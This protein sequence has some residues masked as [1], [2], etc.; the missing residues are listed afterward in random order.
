[1]CSH[2]QIVYEAKSQEESENERGKI[3]KEVMAENSPNLRK[4][5]VTVPNTKVNPNQN[6]YKENSPRHIVIKVMR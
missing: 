4:N 2:Y 5:I 6:H 3:F 1:M